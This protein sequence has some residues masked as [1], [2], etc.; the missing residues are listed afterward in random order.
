LECHVSREKPGPVWPS[1]PA[2]P[3][4]ISLQESRR[5]PLMGTSLSG[6]KQSPGLGTE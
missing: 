2:A 1:Q 4:Q 5:R 3:S 6:L